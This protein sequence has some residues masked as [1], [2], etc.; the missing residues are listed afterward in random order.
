[1]SWDELEE[2]AKVCNLA[3]GL[4]E[5][6][7]ELLVQWGFMIDFPS[8][9]ASGKFFSPKWLSELLVTCVYPSP[10]LQSID[11]CVF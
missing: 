3:D 4:Y 7:R 6:A 8:S 11:A 5:R 2:M 1:M 10:A 9:G